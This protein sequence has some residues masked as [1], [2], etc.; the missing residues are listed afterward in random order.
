MSF[1]FDGQ[2]EINLKLER[3]QSFHLTKDQYGALAHISIA[4][5]NWAGVEPYE[6]RLLREGGNGDIIP[7]CDVILYGHTYQYTIRMEPQLARSTLFA[8]PLD[9]KLSGPGCEVHVHKFRDTDY[10]GAILA[11]ILHYE[12]APSVHSLKTAEEYLAEQAPTNFP[13][14]RQ[15]DL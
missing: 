11:A 2:R 3:G 12:G 10:T 7:G 14:D 13:I 8:L 15:L 9:S 4:A 6:I 1:E 5:L